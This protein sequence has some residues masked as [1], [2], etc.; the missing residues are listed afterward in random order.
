MPHSDIFPLLVVN[1]YKLVDKYIKKDRLTI[2]TFNYKR[3]LDNKRREK[4]ESE[5]R[6]QNQVC[7]YV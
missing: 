2:N 1:I 3:V 6:E 5:R 4:R 7:V